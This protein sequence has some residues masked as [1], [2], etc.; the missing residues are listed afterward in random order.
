M[1]DFDKQTTRSTFASTDFSSTFSYAQSSEIPSYLIDHDSKA[2]AETV[3]GEI[4]SL[5]DDLS[6][7]QE[8]YT[9]LMLP[10]Q[11]LT[12]CFQNLVEH[13]GVWDIP[14]KKRRRRE[15]P[16]S[17][18]LERDWEQEIE[19]CTKH[20]SEL[21]ASYV[22]LSFT[23]FVTTPANEYAQTTPAYCIYSPKVV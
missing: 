2:L 21:E 10:I 9:T 13:S 20:L 5:Y 14:P 22:L 16:A 6:S 18:S 3:L 7:L 11:N 17:S 12:T 4:I 15:A 23:T 8:V 19:D 1:F